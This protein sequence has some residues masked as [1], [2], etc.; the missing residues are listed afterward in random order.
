M[1]ESEQ[2][3]ETEES[4][5]SQQE[6]TEQ[7]QAETNPAQAQPSGV[8]DKPLTPEEQEKLQRMQALMNKVPNDPG[9]LL[10]RKMELEYQKRKRQSAPP[11]RTKQW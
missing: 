3:S 4:D 7:E 5:N 10:K 2:P 1:N 6:Q 9:F 8:S 11:A